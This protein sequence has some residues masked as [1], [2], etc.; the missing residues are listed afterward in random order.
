MN[1]WAQDPRSLTPERRPMARIQSFTDAAAVLLQLG[2]SSNE[3][4]ARGRR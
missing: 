4:D 3:G 1:R 2:P